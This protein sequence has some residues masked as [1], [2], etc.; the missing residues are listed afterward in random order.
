MSTQKVEVTEAAWTAMKERIDA[1]LAE[2]EELRE[3]G[4]RLHKL[5]QQRDAQVVQLEMQLAAIAAGRVTRQRA[6]G[7]R[8]PSANDAPKRAKRAQGSRTDRTSPR[9]KSRFDRRPKHCGPND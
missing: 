5:V 4:R 3:A 1:L 7:T 2:N 8:A 6:C 9:T